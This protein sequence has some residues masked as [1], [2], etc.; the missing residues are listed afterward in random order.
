[1][2]D[3][4]VLLSDLVARR[5]LV[6]L[7]IGSM[8]R[9]DDAWAKG[10]IEAVQ[11]LNDPQIL[12]F[13]GSTAPESFLAPIARAHPAQVLLCDAGLIPGPAGSYALAPPEEALEGFAFSHRLPLSFLAD[14]IHQR[15]GAV[16]HLLLMRPES[17]ELVESLSP[18]VK[19]G[20]RQLL[21]ELRQAL[22]SST[23]PA[24]IC[25]AVNGSPFPR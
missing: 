21:C 18:A 13:W 8:L 9:G 6:F 11:D 17:L 1:M 3:Y 16:V 19:T 22:Q 7:G 20:L 12:A 15:T 10:L 5:P 2:P 24:S 25:L 4:P 23:Q 14:Q